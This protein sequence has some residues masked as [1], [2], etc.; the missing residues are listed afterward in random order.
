MTGAKVDPT[1]GDCAGTSNPDV[2]NLD[3]LK[4]FDELENEEVAQSGPEKPSQLAR[5]GKKKKK[6][7]SPE[8]KAARRA[9]KLRKLFR[10]VV[11]I[12][13]FCLALLYLKETERSSK[14]SRT[15]VLNMN[16]PITLQM[17]DCDVTFEGVSGSDMTV[18]IDMGS[19]E[20]A[21]AEVN[22]NN[23]RRSPPPSL[24]HSPPS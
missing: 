6:K 4:G 2:A 16:N 14:D 19:S 12:G 24:G 17:R 9:S 11:L 1:D 15:G 7:I 22:L 23:V 13:Y 18:S 3:D 8:L 5:P 10:I 21:F 20:D